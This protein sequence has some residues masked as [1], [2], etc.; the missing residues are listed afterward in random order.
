MNGW[1]D[2]PH[3]RC[4]PFQRNHAWPISEGDRRFLVM[5]PEEKLPEA[6][7]IKHEVVNGG[8]EALYAWLLAQDLGDFDPQTKPPSTPAQRTPGGLE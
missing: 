6:R 5:W 7:Q 1:E 3:E 2:Q 4:V 8:V